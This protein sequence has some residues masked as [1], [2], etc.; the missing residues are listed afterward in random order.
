MKFLGPAPSNDDDL[1][2][3]DD[4]EP[5]IAPGTTDQY[6]RGDKTWQSTSTLGGGAGIGTIAALAGG[7][8]LP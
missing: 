3:K 1:I 5:P 6:W 7:V 2:T 8:F 4:A